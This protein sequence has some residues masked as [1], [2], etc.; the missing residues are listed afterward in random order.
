[1]SDTKPDP[2]FLRP[3]RKICPVC[4]TTS[5]SASGMHPQCAMQQA[6]APRMERLKILRKEEEA[7]E[8][9]Q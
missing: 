1:M 6:D 9:P 3:H 7:K 8:K 5:Y 4:G 2:L